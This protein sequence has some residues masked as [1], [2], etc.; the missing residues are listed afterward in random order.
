MVEEVLS[1]ARPVD[2][3]ICAEI[4]AQH[5]PQEM[6]VEQRDGHVVARSGSS[7]REA[8]NSAC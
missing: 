2:V 6:V 8:T 1:R 4:L 3:S 7:E 5:V